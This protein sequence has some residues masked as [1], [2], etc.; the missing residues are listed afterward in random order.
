MQEV[1]SQLQ[2]LCETRGEG[3]AALSLPTPLCSDCF[4]PMPGAHSPAL[5]DPA[6]ASTAQVCPGGLVNFEQRLL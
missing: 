4:L 5:G 1:L 3:R 6:V 2:K